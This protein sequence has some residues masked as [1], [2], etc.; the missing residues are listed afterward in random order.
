MG[1]AI[2]LLVSMVMVCKA[3]E[4]KIVL[5]THTIRPL[6]SDG[7]M[8]LDELTEKG[9]KL[10]LTAVGTLDHHEQIL[11]TIKEAINKIATYVKLV[12]MTSSNKGIL[13]IPGTEL[14]LGNGVHMGAVGI[15]ENFPDAKEILGKSY[16]EKIE[17]VHGN[18]ALSI[19]CHPAWGDNGIYDQVDAIECFNTIGWDIQHSKESLV[20]SAEIREIEKLAQLWKSQRAKSLV[21][22]CDAHLQSISYGYTFVFA[23]SPSLDSLLWAIQHGNCYPSKNGYRVECNWLPSVE[24]KS[25]EQVII[26]AKIDFGRPF[27]EKKKLIIFRDGE[28]IFAD[29]YRPKDK[30]ATSFEVNW[31]DN[32]AEIGNHVYCLYLPGEIR[33]QF[34]AEIQKPVGSAEGEIG[35]INVDPGLTLPKVGETLG[36]Y[37]PDGQVTTEV[38]VLKV[39]GREVQ[40]K[41]ISGPRPQGNRIT[42]CLISK[43]VNSEEITKSTKPKN[44][45]SLM[46]G[47]KTLCPN[48]AAGFL[49]TSNSLAIPIISGDKD[50][51][52]RYAIVGIAL[53]LGKG[54]IIALGGNFLDA[55]FYSNSSFAKNVV[56]WLGEPLEKY[57]LLIT[58][59]HREIFDT[60]SC[61]MLNLRYDLG[62]EGYQ[63]DQ[64]FWLDMTPELLQKI[65][66]VYIGQPYEEFSPSE[67]EALK[68]FVKAGGGLILVGRVRDWL[69]Y[70]EWQHQV[71][72]PKSYPL[73]SVD[74]FPL[75]KIAKQ[76]GI[77]WLDGEI[78]DPTDH[79]EGAPLFHIFYPNIPK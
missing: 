11:A 36:I 13:L 79:F 17:I 19:L 60:P 35:I 72:D 56:K 50:T 7:T 23:D 32:T 1:W 21:G 54:R 16:A 59:N 46:T 73:S 57:K 5:H 47:I 55:N 37:G 52:P 74:D 28:N 69:A 58:C 20:K 40:I 34:V 65:S 67:I 2:F 68:D 45:T 61:L 31:Q 15:K 4:Y 70:K 75:N 18:E 41:I 64:G 48:G 14:D 43:A 44:L 26:T 71:L 38:V 77:R 6:G 53:A 78:T 27:K 51:N 49:A 3:G 12:R 42:W 29:Y 25:T 39:T 33:Y 30:N 10:G 24:P 22:G 62:H 63:V 8:T 66:I 76:F 9:K